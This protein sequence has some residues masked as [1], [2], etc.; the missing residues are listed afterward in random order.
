VA[1]LS[2]RLSRVLKNQCRHFVR[3]SKL[4][5]SYCVN[6]SGTLIKVAEENSGAGGGADIRDS[7]QKSPHIEE[8]FNTQTIKKNIYA[9]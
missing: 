9:L 2:L 5:L 3:E 7:V 6:R 8:L 1:R 4:Y